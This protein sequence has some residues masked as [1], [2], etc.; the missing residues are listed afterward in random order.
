[1]LLGDAAEGVNSGVEREELRGLVS[2]MTVDWYLIAAGRDVAL[3][4]D[5]AWD[6]AR[7]VV[8][9]LPLD[10]LFELVKEVVALRC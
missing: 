7:A 1:M 6:F 3:D 5:E 10:F 8:H 9:L 2:G 4:S